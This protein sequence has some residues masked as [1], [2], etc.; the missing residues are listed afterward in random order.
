MLWKQQIEEL[1]KQISQTEDRQKVLEAMNNNEANEE[2]TQS[3]QFID[4][5]IGLVDDIPAL[6]TTK[7]S[8]DCRLGFLKEK[9][10]KMKDNLPFWNLYLNVFLH[11]ALAFSQ[12][13][14]VIFWQSHFST[15]LFYTILALLFYYFTT[16]S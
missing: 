11:Y 3:V 4:E 13:P 6:R 8:I 5:A 9:Y 12:I 1:Q 7:A 10:Y 2:M 15:L 16:L 14:F